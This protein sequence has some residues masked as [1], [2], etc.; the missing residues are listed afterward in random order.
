MFNIF[1]IR[2]EQQRLDIAKSIHRGCPATMFKSNWVYDDHSSRVVTSWNVAAFV[3]VA[4]IAALDLLALI[5]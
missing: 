5:K 1:S 3:F 4:S 2:T